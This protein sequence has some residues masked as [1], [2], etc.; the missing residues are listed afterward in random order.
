MRILNTRTIGP[1][2]LAALHACFAISAFTAE[3]RLG[4]VPQENYVGMP[5]SLPIQIIN[6]TDHDPPQ[7]EPVDGLNIQR[8]IKPSQSTSSQFIQNGRDIRTTSTTTYQYNFVVTPEREG[9]FTIR[10]IKVVA[11]GVATVTRAVTIKVKGSETGDL[12]FLE[13]E[14]NEESV[15]VGQPLHVTL[16]IL[17]KQFQDKKM[18]VAVSE[19]DTW[20]MIQPRSEWGLFEKRMQELQDQRQR[21]RGELVVRNDAVGEPTRY[22]A[23][24]LDA[25]IYPKQAGEIDGSQ[26]RIVAHYPTGLR[27][28]DDR[29][30]DDF[31]PGGLFDSFMGPRV[32]AHSPRPIEATASSLPVQI[33]PIPTEGRPDNYRGAV[34]RYRILTEVTPR[35]CRVGE[36]LQ[37][38]I[39]VD[40]DQAG[41]AG[42]MELVRAPALSDFGALTDHFKVPDEPLAGFVDGRRKVFSTTIRPRSN[43]VAEVPA[44]PYSFFDPAEEKFVTV[45]SDPIA[46]EVEDAEMLALDN[47]VSGGIDKASPQRD[48]NAE[49]ASADAAIPLTSQQPAA[50]WTWWFGLLLIGPPALSVLIQLASRWRDVFRIGNFLVPAERSFRTAIKRAPDREGV[51]TA[52]QIFLS[53]VTSTPNTLEERLAAIGKLRASGR[54]TAAVVAER[55]YSKCQ[56]H[57]VPLSNDDQLASLKQEAESIANWLRSDASDRRERTLAEAQRIATSMLVAVT[58]LG[59]VGEANADSHVD[60]SPDQIRALIH[61]ADEAFNSA[62]KETE[63]SESDYAR[64]AQ[65][66]QILID[67]GV[68]N[69]Q[70]SHRAGEAYLGAGQR[71]RAVAA[72]R[73]ALR[74]EPANTRYR[75]SLAKATT[76]AP[77]SGGEKLTDRWFDRIFRWKNELITIVPLNAV[78][79]L[80]AVSWVAFWSLLSLRL[81]NR[82]RSAT[83]A[84]AMIAVAS[85]WIYIDT[86]VDSIQDGT[87]VLLEERVDLLEGDDPTMPVVASIQPAAGVVVEEINHR[88]EWTQ[89]RWRERVGWINSKSIESIN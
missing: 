20:K 43:Q 14:A 62:M 1:L 23:F 55:V 80:F 64:A 71:G 74:Y 19:R 36:P 87:A 50:L 54:N 16:R 6:A 9:T 69:A 4:N 67:G 28:L 70:L 12:M 21:P 59:S 45:F 81:T 66:Y 17:I 13:V 61:E 58:F 2:V 42:P 22:F 15:Y 48:S 10:P 76:D 82:I 63:T 78:L 86:V 31:F 24:E 75:M 49:E 29:F 34:G 68:S 7:I 60:H 84:A 77:P 52:L 47:V 37:L 44:I 65:L 89:V 51:A 38:N 72:F 27:R 85:G 46:I 57:S 56:S 8:P 32:A 73:R 79:A 25:K 83:V 33:K 30:S 35:S 26:I 3:V 39:A 41:G 18:G 53:R 88:G 40:S 5:I 11:D